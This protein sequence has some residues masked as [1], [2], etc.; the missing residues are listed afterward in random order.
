M[1]ANKLFLYFLCFTFSFFCDAHEL[2]SFYTSDN[3]SIAWILSKDKLDHVP[4]VNVAKEDIPVNGI[5]RTAFGRLHTI[6]LE[7]D[8]YVVTSIEMNPIQNP[9]SKNNK[10]FFIVRF[11]PKDVKNFNSDDYNMIQIILWNLEVVK[12]TLE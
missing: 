10:W 9:F 4:V 12:P 1:N 6:G 3:K 11:G 7:V 8:D 5:V 2:Y